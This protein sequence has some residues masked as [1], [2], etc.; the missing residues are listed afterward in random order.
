M[1]QKF[2]IQ[3][4]LSYSTGIQPKNIHRLSQLLHHAKLLK[5][6]VNKEHKVLHQLKARSQTKGKSM[7]IGDEETTV[8]A[9]SCRLCMLSWKR[10]GEP[11][12]IAK[13]IH[14]IKRNP[15]AHAN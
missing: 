13:Y 5:G 9:R 4:L 12:K 7:A 10:Q 8:P 15:G 14:Q 3:P 1:S 11:K 2:W 6:I